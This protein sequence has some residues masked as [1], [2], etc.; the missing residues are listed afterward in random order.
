MFSSALFSV[1]LFSSW[2]LFSSLLLLFSSDEFVSL[3]SVLSAVTSCIDNF[4]VKIQPL[5][6]LFFMYDHNP[7]L[8]ITWYFSPDLALFIMSPFIN[9]IIL[10]WVSELVVPS[11]ILF[12]CAVC[13]EFLFSS[14]EFVSS[15]LFSTEL[16]LSSFLFSSALFSVC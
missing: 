12:T 16:L 2:G 6:S 8:L 11:C 5:F 1:F 7:T 13:S 4:S 9:G 10:I 14:D 3:F 15:D